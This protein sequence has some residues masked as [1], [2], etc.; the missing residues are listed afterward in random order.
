MA[1]AGLFLLQLLSGRD[2]SVVPSALIG[3]EAPA[4]KPAAA[5]GMDLPGIDSSEFEGQ[6]TLV[7]VWAS[8]CVPCRQEHPYLMALA[9]DGRVNIAGINYKDRPENARRFLGELGNPFHSIGVDGSG[10]TAIDWGVYGVPETFLVGRDGTI[11]YKHVGPF[12]PPPSATSWC[13]R[14]R[15]RS[16]PN[17]HGRPAFGARRAAPKSSAFL[18]FSHGWTWGWWLVAAL[19]AIRSGGTIWQMPAAAAFY[20]G[21]AGVMLGGI[22]MTLRLGGR[23]GL[24]DLARRTL[25]PRPSPRWWLIVLA[26]YPALTFGGGHAGAPFGCSTSTRRSLA[27]VARWPI[28][29]AARLS[30]LHHADRPAARGNRLARLPAR[31]AAGAPWRACGEP[32]RGS[33]LV[34]L[35]PAARPAAGL[36]R[37]LLAPARTSRPAGGA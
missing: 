16:R 25:D 7:N 1:L 2:A 32:V 3:A 37:G 17:R 10:R 26:W 35:A 9:E 22:V 4:T 6:V 31:P 5:G 13:R 12:T 18:L 15:R 36:F 19:L 14:S 8:W 21:G 27:A 20:L 29:R 28:R 34:E 23:P 30:R 11:V 24:A 33:R